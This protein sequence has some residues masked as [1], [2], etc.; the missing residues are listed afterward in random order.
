MGMKEIFMNT[1]CENDAISKLQESAREQGKQI[2]TADI[3]KPAKTL[4]EEIHAL[5]AMPSSS[6][7]NPDKL[8]D[9]LAKHASLQ[10]IMANEAAE[11]QKTM[12]WLTIVVLIAAIVQAVV[13][14][15]R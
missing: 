5:A 2:A 7:F 8:A 13:A 11:L 3:G 15:C 1:T 9:T 12:K 6:S 10:V 14:V 4:L